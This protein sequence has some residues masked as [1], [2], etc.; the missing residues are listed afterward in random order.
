MIPA[1]SPVQGQSDRPNGLQVQVSQISVT[2]CRIGDTTSKLQL[3]RTL[4]EISRGRL[5]KEACRQFPRD[6]DDLL[7]VPPGFSKHLDDEDSPYF[8]KT[9]ESVLR[10]RGVPGDKQRATNELLNPLKK[11]QSTTGLMYYNMMADS[12]KL[13]ATKDIWCVSVDQLWLEFVGVPSSR[14][15]PVPFIEAFPLTIWL[16]RPLLSLQ[17]ESSTSVL[18]QSGSSMTLSSG[19]DDSALNGADQVPRSNSRQLLKDYYADS[20][21]TNG[22]NPTFKTTSQAQHEARHLPPRPDTQ[23]VVAR[24][25][26]IHMITNIGAKVSI[27][28]HYHY[29]FLFPFYEIFVYFD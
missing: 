17:S 20:G 4:D 16:C 27:Q 19:E 26:D 6:Q 2:N 3:L 14:N 28:Y 18:S 24:L 9:V 25:G 13:D 21:L 22:P 10:G 12:F 29:L 11:S 8:D 5:F 1:D 7:C 23:P 15:R